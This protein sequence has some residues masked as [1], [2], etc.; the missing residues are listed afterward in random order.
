MKL[1][2]F[3]KTYIPSLDYYSSSSSKDPNVVKI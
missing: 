3:I 2:E 1:H